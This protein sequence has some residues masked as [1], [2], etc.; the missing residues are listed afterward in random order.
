MM[1][2]FNRAIQISLFFYVLLFGMVSFSQSKKEKELMRAAELKDSV[3]QILKKQIDSLSQKTIDLNSEI[4]NEKQ[5]IQKL[6][7]NLLA[8]SVI[9]QTWANANLQVT[10]LIDGTPIEFA[11]TKEK[12]DECFEKKKPAYCIHPNDSSGEFG[13]L[14][15]IYAIQS[16]KLAPEGWRIPT[17][18]EMELLI[19]NIQ[20]MSSDGA[21]FIKAT[22]SL[23]GLPNWETSG[24]DVFRF[25]LRPLG[26]RLNDGK[27][28]YFGNKIYLW[29][30]SKSNNLFDF[31]VVTDFNELPFLLE[32]ELGQ[33]NYGLYVRCIK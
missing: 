5:L 11:D 25:G 2:K 4:E 7:G 21:K 15:N 32:K 16:K 30:S 9:D 20:L 6:S 33:E 13:F 12:W 1:N 3:I 24:L 8:I 28:W 10:Q 22:R 14:Y 17:K 18:V 26:F 23:K 31:M 27:Q 29:C 19:K